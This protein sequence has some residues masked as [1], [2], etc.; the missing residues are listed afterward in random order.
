MSGKNLREAV[1]CKNVLPMIV[2]GTIPKK[3]ESG[4][5]GKKVRAMTSPHDEEGTQLHGFRGHSKIFPD[6]SRN[7]QVHNDLRLW[8]SDEQHSL[9]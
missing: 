2:S 9:S 5:K 8:Y 4:S 3:F 7:P 6:Q 1:F